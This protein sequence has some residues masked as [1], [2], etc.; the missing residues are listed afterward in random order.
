MLQERV[1]HLYKSCKHIFLP[2]T[3]S[4]M[5]ESIFL[6]HVESFVRVQQYAIKLCILLLETISYDCG[7]MTDIKPF[8]F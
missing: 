2:K 1:K 7:K 3:Y 8:I 6:K 5:Y 4:A